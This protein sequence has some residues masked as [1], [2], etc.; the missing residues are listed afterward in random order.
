MDKLRIERYN[1]AKWKISVNSIIPVK[2]ID[3]EEN[4]VIVYGTVNARDL[5]DNMSEI[6]FTH[7]YKANKENRIALFKE[8]DE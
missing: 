2:S 5:K 7:W 4:W 6:N 1:F 3:R 8:F